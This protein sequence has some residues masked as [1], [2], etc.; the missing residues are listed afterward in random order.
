MEDGV[1]VTLPPMLVGLADTAPMPPLLMLVGVES[2]MAPMSPLP[3][4]Q[5][6]VVM[7]PTSLPPLTPVGVVSDTVSAVSVMEELDTDTD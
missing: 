5:D 2:V 4:T 6:G 1:E 7:V 3:H